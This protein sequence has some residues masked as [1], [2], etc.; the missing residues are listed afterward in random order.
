MLNI[1]SRI[2]GQG[3][4]AQPGLNQGPQN[5]GSASVNGKGSN[6]DFLGSLSDLMTR[7]ELAAAFS[8][9]TS[10]DLRQRN[11]TFLKAIVSLAAALGM[12]VLLNI[13]QFESPPN[14]KYFATTPSGSLIP[15]VPLS[16]PI[17]SLPSIYRWTIR[18]TDKAFTLSFSNYIEDENRA[19]GAMTPAGIASYRVGLVKYS[20]IETLKKRYNLTAVAQ[21]G[22]TLRNEGVLPDGRAFW[23]I[24]FKMLWHYSSGQRDG[25]GSFSDNVVAQVLV[26]RAP[27]TVAPRG[28]EIRQ[29]LVRRA[30]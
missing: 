3:K 4:P 30:Q 23:L 10:R 14:T 20:I 18:N 27:Q 9:W 16:R 28:L 1:A 25:G 19:E 8:L 6:H 26:V 17:M 11:A 15:I 29:F 2:R 5:A 12:S 21:S 13:V 7:P 22:A 24:Q